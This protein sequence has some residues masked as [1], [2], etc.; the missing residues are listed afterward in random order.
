MTK[1]D[2]LTSVLAD[3]GL[4]CAV[5]IKE[6]KVRTRFAN[7]IPTLEVEIDAL[8]AAGADAYFSMASYEDTNPPRRLASNVT[9]LKSFWLD[10]D[11]GDN[12]PYPTREDAIAAIRELGMLLEDGAVP[13]IGCARLSL[14]MVEN[15][16][17]D[18]P[19]R[20]EP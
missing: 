18:L 13:F 3:S 7:D 6:G 19:P 17:D 2:F 15:Y 20:D 16:A 9:T 8:H 5:G 12:K 11:C 14:E 1:N 10:L 4:Y